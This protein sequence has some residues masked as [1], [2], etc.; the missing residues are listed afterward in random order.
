MNFSENVPDPPVPL[1]RALPTVAVL[2]LGLATLMKTAVLVTLP[3]AAVTFPDT[4]N[5]P[6]AVTD[7]GVTETET[8]SV[9]AEAANGRKHSNTRSRDTLIAILT[10]LIVAECRRETLY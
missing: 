7:V 3:D 6:A 9:A 1:T 5:A 10:E 4:V 8:E 2:L